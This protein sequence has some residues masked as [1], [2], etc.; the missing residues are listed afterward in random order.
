MFLAPSFCR[1]QPVTGCPRCFWLWLRPHI[2]AEAWGEQTISFMNRMQSEGGRESGT[3]WPLKDTVPV[4]RRL[5][6]RLQLLKV[7]TFPH[8]AKQRT[9]DFLSHVCLEG[10]QTL[11]EF[12]KIFETCKI[13]KVSREG[14]VSF[15]IMPS[16]S[17][18]SI[19]LLVLWLCHKPLSSIG[20]PGF[21][22]T[23]VFGLR[24]P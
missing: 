15:L 22:K 21:N 10:I 7:P 20:S 1:L 2:L 6:T 13:S 12:Q 4:T 11:L 17:L 24:I 18:A 14:L 9:K 3:N 8:S 19:Y 16:L 5:P 23:L